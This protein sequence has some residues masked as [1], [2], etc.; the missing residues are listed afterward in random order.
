MNIEIIAH[1]GP[2]MW[3]IL[4]I[5]ATGGILFLQSFFHLHRAHIKTSDFMRGIFNIVQKGNIVEAVSQCEETPGPVSQMV[6]MA[7]LEREHGPERV[8]DVMREVGLAEIPRMEKNLSLLLTL[9]QVAP[10]AG[11]L[12]TVLGMLEVLTSISRQAPQVYAGDLSAGLFSALLTTAA[13]I[14]V[15]ILGYAGYNMLVNRVE[16][17]TLDMERVFGE[18]MSIMI[19][20]E[21]TT[22]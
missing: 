11:L 8:R 5:S 6:R 10:L 12:G 17:I 18:V 9:A 19:K 22:R 3:L 1:G 4:L 7:I 21:S 16:S 14:L 15:A 13:G 20:P 2:V